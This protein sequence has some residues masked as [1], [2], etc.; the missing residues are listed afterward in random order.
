MKIG[1]HVSN[2]GQLMLEGSI[3]EA[4]SYGANCFM[5]YLGAPQNT[6][7]KPL[8]AMNASAMKRLALENN[9]NLEDIII[10]A[11]YIVNLGRIDDEKHSFAVDFLT[12][13][14]VGVASIG[15]KYLVL[16][17]GSHTDCET[18]VSIKQIAKGINQIIKNTEGLNVVICLET[19]AGKGNEVG[20]SFEEIKAIIDLVVDQ[21]RIGVCLDTCHLNDAGYDLVN[22]YEEV[23]LKFNQII[24]LDY[25]KVIHINDSKNILDSHKD[26]HENIGF[27]NIGF[28]TLLRVIND[29]DFINIP[30]ILETPY[31]PSLDNK[32]TYPPYKWEIAMIKRGVFDS[33][34][35]MQIIEASKKE[36]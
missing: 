15:C 5:V 29:E 17:P 21:N 30:K 23:K 10:H 16:H 4:L 32:E 36:R 1:S 8:S 35:K 28:D 24:G 31:V 7:R 34:L 13:E 19:M 20:R 33:N 26:R 11:P 14:V 9:I 18:E 22:H 6:I 12:K 27:G 2:N 3:R 25:L